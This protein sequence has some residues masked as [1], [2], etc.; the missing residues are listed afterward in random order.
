M[1]DNK[2]AKG[3]ADRR[4]VAK[5]EGYEVSYFAR[6]HDITAEQARKLIDKIGNNREKLNS[7]AEKLN[8]K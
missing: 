1:S 4:Q 8:K 5:G 2:K 6:K 7:A 3:A